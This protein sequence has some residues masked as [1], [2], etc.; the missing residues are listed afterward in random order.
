MAKFLNTEGVTYHLSQIINNAQERLFL[1]SP[2]LKINDRLKESLQYKD[3][4][5]I[6][7]RII[8]GKSE[9][10]PSELNWLK[11]LECVRTSFYKELHA[12][13]YLNEKEA[14]I[15]SMNLFEYSQV[16]NYEMGIYLDRTIDSELY[17]SMYDE[18]IR[19]IQNSKEVKISVSEIP[20]KNDVL[21]NPAKSGMKTSGYCIRCHYDVKLNP[22]VPYCKSC[23]SIWKKDKKE[24]QEEKYCHICG[25]PNKST[26]IKPTCYSCFKANKDVLEFPLTKE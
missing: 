13:C 9:L 12:K 1:I 18:V 3:K 25:K 7:I 23:Y 14:I 22:T 11:S 8:Y 4:F 5:K 21:D 2:Y 26:L 19:L 16:N 6:D 15:T 10:Q 24:D 20:Y 17:K